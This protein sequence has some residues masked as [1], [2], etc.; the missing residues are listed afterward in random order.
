MSIQDGL[1]ATF[2]SLMMVLTTSD[3][4]HVHNGALPLMGG[5]AV[6]VLAL[7]AVGWLGRLPLPLVLFCLSSLAGSLVSRGTAYPARFSIHIIGATVALL[8]CA[9][10]IAA[11]WTIQRWPHRA[12]T[13]KS[14]PRAVVPAT[15]A[16]PLR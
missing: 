13:L 2:D 15:R 14:G 7:T 3:P 5:V 4:P 9:L 8:V 1:A 11:S 6:A 16:G 12:I 10:S